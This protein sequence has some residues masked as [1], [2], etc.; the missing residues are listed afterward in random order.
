MKRFF[1]SPE[2]REPASPDEKS[3]AMRQAKFIMYVGEEIMEHLEQD[4][5]F[6]EWMQNKLSALHQEA[7]S[8]HATMAGEYEDDEDEDEEDDDMNESYINEKLSVSD[9][10]GA[11]IDD[12]K[13]SDAPQFKGKSEKERRD[14]AIAAFLSAKRGG[15]SMDEAVNEK[16]YASDYNVGAKKSQFG[17]YTPTVTHKKKGH[18]MYSAQQT[19]KTPDHAKAHANAYLKGYEAMGQQHANRKASEYAKANK[20]HIHRES[21]DLDEAKSYGPGHIGAI[22]RMLDKEREIKKA[23]GTAK[24]ESAEIE[25][26]APKMKGDWLKKER[27]RNRAH[28][29]AMGRTPTGRKKPVR[30]MT[31]TQRS[32]ASLRK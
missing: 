19:Y 29:A 16:V 12:F 28:D 24:K 5:D 6:P 25:E 1:E 21:V 3:M 30:T 26:K 4:N 8:M 27:E 31:S 10:M 7:K 11:W 9:G 2:D 17:G 13:K 20:Q 23:K 15:K 22:Q 18:T 14:M 32:L